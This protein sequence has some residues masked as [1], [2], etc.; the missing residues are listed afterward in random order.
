MAV[1]AATAL[2]LSI[3]LP[4]VFLALVSVFSFYAAFSGYRILGLRRLGHGDKP[5]F[6]DWFAALLSLGT[7]AAL[8]LLGAFRP[9][10]A[11][12][13][14]LVLVVLGLIGA[15]L[16]A[17]SIRVFLRPPADKQFWWYF[18]MRGMI[19]S[20]IA[21]FTAF[22]VVNLTPHFGNVWWVWLGPAIIGVPG[23]NCWQLYYRRKFSARAG[24]P[25]QA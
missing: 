14:S 6:I 10:L 8:A 20:Y 4:I 25:I 18:H 24:Q 9:R 16:A 12:G 3:V 19:A 13:M 21:A 22:T 17:G 2:F 1:V 15:L 7:S 11:G 23:S 5:H